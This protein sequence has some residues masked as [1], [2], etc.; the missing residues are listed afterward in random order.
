LS[1]LREYERHRIERA[2]HSLSLYHIVLFGGD[3]GRTDMLQP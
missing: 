1:L 3:W 2:S